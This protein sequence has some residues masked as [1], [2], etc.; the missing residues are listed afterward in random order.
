MR[1]SHLKETRLNGTIFLCI[2]RSY[3]EKWFQRQKSWN[4]VPSSGSSSGTGQGSDLGEKILPCVSF[5]LAKQWTN[6]TAYR[7]LLHCGCSG[8]LKLDATSDIVTTKNA[9]SGEL[10]MIFSSLYYSV[11]L[12]KKQRL[13]N[14]TSF[15]Y[16]HHLYL[17]PGEVLGGSFLF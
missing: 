14:L 10:L 12:Q 2:R 9:L 13:L 1:S 11:I 3:V 6:S 16:N 5:P 15:F 7:A 8:S 4:G 17:F